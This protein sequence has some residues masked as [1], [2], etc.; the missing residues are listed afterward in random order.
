MHIVGLFSTL[1]KILHASIIKAL[2]HYPLHLN[3]KPQ[4]YLTNEDRLVSMPPQQRAPVLLKWFSLYLHKIRW[5]LFSL[6]LWH[7]YPLLH[8]GTPRCFPDLLPFKMYKFL[9]SFIGECGIRTLPRSTWILLFQSTLCLP[10][11]FFLTINND[12]NA[13]GLKKKQLMQG[14]LNCSLHLDRPTTIKDLWNVSDVQKK[15]I[16]N[17]KKHR[18]TSNKIEYI[19][20]GY[21]VLKLHLVHFNP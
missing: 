21:L 8:P 1:V 18:P 5:F 19:F 6:S 12:Y 2:F 14:L 4:T 3:F 11:N 15:R 10:Q 7:I 20:N 17:C 9:K 16:S 13:W